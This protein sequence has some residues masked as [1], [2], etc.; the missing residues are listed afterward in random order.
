MWKVLLELKM[1]AEGH[2][3]RFKKIKKDS[4]IQQTLRVT[5][6]ESMLLIITL[7]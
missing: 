3:V 5:G 4:T 7:E 2:S 1:Y 6:E